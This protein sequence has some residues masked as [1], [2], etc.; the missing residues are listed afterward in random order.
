M[1]KASVSPASLH[2]LGRAALAEVTDPETVGADAGQ[3]DESDGVVSVYFETTMTGYPGWQWTVS[4]ATLDGQEPS[5]LET[6]LVPADGA[7]LAPDWIPW[8]DRLAEYKAAQEAL[9]DDADVLD[10]DDGDLLDGDLL[11]GDDDGDDVDDLDEL[12]SDVVHSGDV[13]GVD[14]DDLDDTD[15]DDTDLDDTDDDDTDLDSDGASR[16]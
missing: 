10:G 9:G 1:P 12:G 14:I 15:L 3:A 16:G 5:V 2:D 6:E 11:D 4:I 7:L 13:D 8:S